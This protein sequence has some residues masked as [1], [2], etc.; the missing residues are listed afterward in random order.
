M[1]IMNS[2]VDYLKDKVPDQI[3]TPLLS[4]LISSLKNTVAP[5]RQGKL[6]SNNH[7]RSSS[8]SNTETLWSLPSLDV[9][10]HSS[11]MENSDHGK[12]IYHQSLQMNQTMNAPCSSTWMKTAAQ[13]R[14]GSSNTCTQNIPTESDFCNPQILLTWLMQLIR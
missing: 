13:V 12:K 9:P 11:S 6:R 10:I 1:T 5:R 4:G 8:S 3:W 7:E 14:L 2:L